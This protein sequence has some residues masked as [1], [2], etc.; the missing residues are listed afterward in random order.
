MKTNVS[1]VLVAIVILGAIFA[2][3]GKQNN[4]P[5][6]TMPMNNGSM[7]GMM[8]EN[9]SIAVSG[10]GETNI[11]VASMIVI[12]NPGYV[13]VHEDNNGQPGKIIGVSKLIGPGMVHGVSIQLSRN[14]IAGE[15]LYAMLHKDNGDKT[16]SDTDIPVTGKNGEPIMMEVIVKTGIQTQPDSISM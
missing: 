12:T 13:V 7:S 11:L 16:Y 14:A 5:S 1:I 6:M 9:N 4:T 15:K 8:V 10:Q 2:F 3:T